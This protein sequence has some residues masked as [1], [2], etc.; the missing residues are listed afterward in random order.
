MTDQITQTETRVIERDITGAECGACPP[1]G[2][3]HV[4]VDDL[5]AQERRIA[6]RLLHGDSPQQI[7][8]ALAISTRTVYW[9][10]ENVYV[11]TGA[12]S[13]GEFFAWAYRHRECCGFAALF[14]RSPR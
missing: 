8:L 7:A 13:L 5:T 6:K 1:R 14:E 9:H 11:K 3:K 10:Q 4:E 12:R 2:S